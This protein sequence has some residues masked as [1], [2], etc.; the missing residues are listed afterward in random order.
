MQIS[1]NTTGMQAGLF[2]TADKQA[3]DHCVVVVKGTFR[4][5]A[6]G[7]MTLASEQ[8]PLLTVDEH[9]GAAETSC[10]RYECDF[11]LE[12]PLTDV[13]VVGKA[14]APGGQPVS[15]LTVGLEIQGRLKEARVFGDRRWVRALGG[16]TASAPVPFTEMPLTLERAFGGQDDSRGPADVSVELDNLV[17]VGFNPHRPN[18]EVEG[19]ALPNIERPQHCVRSPRDLPAPV[20]FGCLGRTSRARAKHAGTYDPRWLDEVYPYLPNDFDS[21]YFQSA[22]EDQRFVH[23]VGGERLRCVHMAAEASVTYAMPTLQVP[24]RFTFID[25]VQER[26][27]ALDTVILEPHLGLATLVWRAS[28]PLGKKLNALRD[29]RVGPRGADD[30]GVVGRRNGKPVFEGLDAAVRSLRQQRSEPR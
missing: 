7:E 25:D 28:V 24:V 12:K 1:R 10:I 17:G 11:V 5:C 23:F 30:H 2:V 3:R 27:G 4:T 8:R 29:I 26:S 20:G 21:R 16:W 18:K 6:T 22:P 14:V 15:Q 13:V 9:Y 19:T